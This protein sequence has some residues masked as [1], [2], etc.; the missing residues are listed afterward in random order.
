MSDEY[1]TV[2]GVRE[3]VREELRDHGITKQKA[4]PAPKKDSHDDHDGHH[5][6]NGWGP[7][8]WEH[9]A[10]HNSW[11]PI[12]MSLGIGVFLFSF[13]STFAMNESMNNYVFSAGSLP[14]VFVGF[15]I[16]SAGLL[17]WWRQDLA[18]DGHYEPKATGV[19]FQ[20]I[21]IRKVGM[22]VFLMSEMMVFSSLFSTYIRYRLGTESCQ[23]I[24]DNHNTYSNGL[25]F[26]PGDACWVPAS[27]FIA[28][29]HSESWTLS[30]GG[31][32][33]PDTLVPGAINTF[34]LI[35][36]SFTVVMALKTAKRE[37]MTSTERSKKV[38]NY[39]AAT[40][41]L[42]VMFLVFKMVEWFIGFNI[43]PFHAPSL[44]EDGFTIHNELYS[45]AGAGHDGGHIDVN[46]RLSAATFFVATGT[47]GAHVFAGIIGLT[48]MTY[49]AH[50][51]GYN[52]DSAESIEYFGL[53][54]HF[55]DL[56]WV[57][58]FPAFYLY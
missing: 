3:I 55:V 14:M 41:V 44:M 58:V 35:I 38:R 28:G 39:L 15:A 6:I 32:G 26:S 49:K 13:A 22:W 31:V 8:D 48:Y 33:L 54:W 25:P 56:V 23:V 57:L 47:H 42:A 52:P 21:D 50:K 34:A 16:I 45:F 5:H 29:S 40:W 1:V 7:H 11:A 9:G 27:Y 36:S 37:D 24:L 17:V 30:L 4:T 10:P 18:F 53:Y 19:P 43:G 20:N 46:L 12:I 51:G 2:D